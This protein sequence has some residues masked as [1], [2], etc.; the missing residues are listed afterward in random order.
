MQIPDMARTISSPARRV[1][2]ILLVDDYDDARASVR[3]ALENGGYAVIEAGNGQ[4]ALNFLVSRPDERVALI[5]LDLQ[6]P[7]M[8][9]WQLL[10]LLRCYVA[11]ST[12]PVIIVTA[13]GP[14]AEGVR[15][16]HVFGCIHAPY[17]IEKLLQM[18]DDCM[19]GA[20]AAGHDLTRRALFDQEAEGFVSN[21]AGTASRAPDQRARSRQAT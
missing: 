9:G 18:V 1:G 5:V 4:Q 16:A 7:I 15:H 19:A 17:A 10:E 13:L 2:P 8:D 12:I 3:E 6:M 11:L 14:G 20:R 21:G